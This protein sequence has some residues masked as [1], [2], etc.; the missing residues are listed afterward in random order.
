MPSEP[1]HLKINFDRIVALGEVGPRRASAFLK[2]GLSALKSP[3]EN[4]NLEGGVTYQ[5]LKHPLSPEDAAEIHSE[6]ESW[7]VS[8]ALKELDHY[9]SLFLDRVWSTIELID[10]HGMTVPSSYQL[11]GK[12]EGDTNVA[13]KVGRVASALGLRLE[14]EQFTSLSRA[15]NCLSHAAGRVRTRDLNKESCLEVS[16]LAPELVV[17]DGDDEIVYRAEP[18]DMYQVKSEEGAQIALRF[19][20]HRMSFPLGERVRLSPHNLAEVCSFY[21]IT[22]SKVVEALKARIAAK[23]IPRIDRPHSPASN[24]PA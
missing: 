2:L 20:I 11:D 8:S 7:I 16:W 24:S 22:S 14:E 18:A 21:Q 6:Y 19:A 17:F 12:F 4:L 13:R 9:F 15:R 5:F 23:N 3:P 1:L 10:L